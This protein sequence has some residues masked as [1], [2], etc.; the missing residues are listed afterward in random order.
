MASAIPILRNMVL[1]QLLGGALLSSGYQLSLWFCD[2]AS[3]NCV[4]DA[5]HNG[6]LSMTCGRSVRWR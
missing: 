6:V 5:P 3:D 1:S 4:I 2:L